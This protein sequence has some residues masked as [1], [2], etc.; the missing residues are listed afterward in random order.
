MIELF[1][2]FLN[3]ANLKIN[4]SERITYGDIQNLKRDNWSNFGPKQPET[5]SFI[6]LS[7]VIQ[8]DKYWYRVAVRF[9]RVE[10]GNMN[11][12]PFDSTL[13]EVSGL[14]PYA[15]FKLE[16]SGVRFDIKESYRSSDGDKIYDYI[17][18]G[19]PREIVESAI[20]NLN[21]HLAKGG[22]QDGV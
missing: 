6:L 21:H 5:Q 20:K 16:Q 8:Y 19:V 1:S 11:M 3:V 17:T 4:F 10:E 12:P 2:M 22:E 14:I 18:K 9:K 15:I 13:Y 7:K